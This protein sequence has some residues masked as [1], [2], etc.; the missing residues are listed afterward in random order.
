[1]T[2]ISISGL[3]LAGVR[4]FF[5]VAKMIPGLSSILGLEPVIVDGIT[6]GILVEEDAKVLMATPEWAKFIASAKAFLESKGA[7]VTL[8]S[9]PAMPTIV[10][11]YVTPANWPKTPTEFNLWQSE[12]PVTP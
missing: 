5:D 1:M 6:L 11:S 7:K 8:S 9:I 2:G 3:L 12:H 4:V 10:T